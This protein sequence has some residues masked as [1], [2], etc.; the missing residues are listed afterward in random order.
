[1]LPEGDAVSL[2]P[3]LFY[4]VLCGVKSISCVEYL[5]HMSDPSVRPRA[6]LQHVSMRVLSF[7]WTH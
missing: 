2:L 4:H 6:V 1:M 3:D 5:L 7:G